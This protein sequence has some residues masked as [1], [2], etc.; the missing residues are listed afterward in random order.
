MTPTSAGNSPTFVGRSGQVGIVEVRKVRTAAGQTPQV[1]V[2]CNARCLF[3]NTLQTII[4]F[5]PRLAAGIRAES[6][7]AST[8]LLVS[9]A[10]ANATYLPLGNM[11]LSLSYS[12][13]LP[14]VSLQGLAV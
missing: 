6:K 5:H 10:A 14:S 3:T 13:I 11:H 2:W 8:C 4:V 9:H 1:S 12:F 7:M